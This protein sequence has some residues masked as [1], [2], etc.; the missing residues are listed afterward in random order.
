MCKNTVA[1]H[2]SLKKKNYKANFNQLNIK[3]VKLI[4]IILEKK[5]T[6]KEKKRCKKIK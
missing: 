1:I 5:T 6:K 4:K 2:I 3:K